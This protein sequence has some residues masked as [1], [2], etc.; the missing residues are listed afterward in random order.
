M[1]LL[2]GVM[3]ECLHQPDRPYGAAG[4]WSHNPEAWN[5]MRARVIEA[6]AAH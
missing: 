4:N 6:I 3:G 2:D 5:R 1:K